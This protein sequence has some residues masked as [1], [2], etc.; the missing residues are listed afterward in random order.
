[1]IHCST[2]SNQVTDCVCSVLLLLLH[3]LDL[4]R[5]ISHQY[6]SILFNSYYLVLRSYFGLYMLGWTRPVLPTLLL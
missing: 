2:N 5:S 1:M 6:A 4:I 3:L